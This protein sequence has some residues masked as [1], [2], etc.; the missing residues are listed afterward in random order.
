M[1]CGVPAPQSPSYEDLAGLVAALEVE[2]RALR[3]D[4]ERLRAENTELRRRLGMDSTNSSRPPSSDSPYAKPS[5]LRGRSGG[6]PGKQRRR[7]SA[8]ALISLGCGGRG[9]R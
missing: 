6:K 9:R 7:A 4:N 5:G 1:I 8:A 2:V 3:E